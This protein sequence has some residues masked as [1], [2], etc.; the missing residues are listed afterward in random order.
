MGLGD[1][2]GRWRWRWM[3]M[4]MEWGSSRRESVNSREP[5]PP[6]HTHQRHRR[7]LR[8]GRRRPRP[9]P[10]VDVLLHLREQLGLLTVQRRHLECPSCPS[11]ARRGPRRINAQTCSWNS[12]SMKPEVPTTAR[13]SACVTAPF[14]TPPRS[15]PKPAPPSRDALRVEQDALRLEASVCICWGVSACRHSRAGATPAAICGPPV[16]TCNHG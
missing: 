4:C 16:G 2:T 7:Q 6:T 11:A 5:P 9:R 8:H 1:G 13:V 14:V 15:V 10:R 3:E 12:G